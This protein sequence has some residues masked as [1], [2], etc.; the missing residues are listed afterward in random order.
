MLRSLRT[1]ALRARPIT[2]PRTFRRPLAVASTETFNKGQTRLPPKAVSVGSF[3]DGEPSKP[4]VT[5]NIPGP[6]ALAAKE[7]MGKLQDVLPGFNVKL[8]VDSGSEHHGVCFVL[9]SR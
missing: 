1:S 6:K 8:T 9:F 4:S 3:L 5:T 2:V 7:S